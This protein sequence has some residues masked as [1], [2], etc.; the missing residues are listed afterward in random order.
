MRCEDWSWLFAEQG[1]ALCHFLQQ[2][3]LCDFSTIFALPSNSPTALCIFCIG[4]WITVLRRWMISVVILR[5]SVLDKYLCNGLGLSNCFATMLLKCGF[6]WCPNLCLWVSEV[7]LNAGNRCT[8]SPIWN[9]LHLLWRALWDFFLT[10]KLLVS[11]SLYLMIHWT[12]CHER[13]SK[14][15]HSIVTDEVWW[16]S[17]KSQQIGHKVCHA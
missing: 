10:F 7:K 17:V 5:F 16:Q 14:S 15:C 3:M 4:A 12:S 2:L 9:R 1:W 13:T 6:T 11:L 8:V